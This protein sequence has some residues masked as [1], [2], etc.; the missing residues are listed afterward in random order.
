M[1]EKLLV[2]VSYLHDSVPIVASGHTEQCQ[3]RH[4]EVVKMGVTAET[5]TRMTKRAFCARSSTTKKQIS[6]RETI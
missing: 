1:A 4:A 5:N 2:C 3:E 6:T